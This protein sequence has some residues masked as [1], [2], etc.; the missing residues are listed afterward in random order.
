MLKKIKKYKRSI[1]YVG[2]VVSIMLLVG[3]LSAVLHHYSDKASNE[4]IR[5]IESERNQES[6]QEKASE[7]IQEETR[8][9]IE[10]IKETEVLPETGTSEK[11]E[12]SMQEQQRYDQNLKAFVMDFQPP[13]TGEDADVN[14]FLDTKEKKEL[15]L[16]AVAEFVF[17]LYEDTDVESIMIG[18]M[19]NETEK[20]L[21]YQIILWWDETDSMPCEIRYDKKGNYFGLY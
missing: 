17:S 19:I 18:T 15:F 2:I 3:I 10:T 8:R 11:S 1:M 7:E 16:K 5:E 12:T 14:Y 9:E 21:K 6:A 4:I 13:I 20:E